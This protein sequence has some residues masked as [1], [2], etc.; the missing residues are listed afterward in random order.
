MIKF[1]QVL[2]VDDDEVSNFITTEM[3]HNI[4]LANDILVAMNGREALDM[5]SQSTPKQESP[6]PKCCPDLIF[7]D[8]NMPIMDGFEFLQACE[9]C[10]ERI[11]VVILTSS[12]NQKDVEAAHK[13]PQV[14]YYLSKPLT[15]DK[16]KKAIQQI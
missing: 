15:P 11:N 12:Y 8:L 13:F 9:S 14:K 5:L 6:N 10:K 1:N 7:L 2:L 16:L 4:D 3:L